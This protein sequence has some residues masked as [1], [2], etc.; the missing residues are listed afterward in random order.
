MSPAPIASRIFQASSSPLSSTVLSTSCL[1]MAPSGIIVA[2]FRYSAAKR[3][4]ESAS[5]ASAPA[6]LA[7]LRMIV[8]RD[9]SWR[10]SAAMSTPVS[11]RS[12]PASNSSP[13]QPPPFAASTRPTSMKARCA[14]RVSTKGC[15]FA[16]ALSARTSAWPSGSPFSAASASSPTSVS[17]QP[18][19]PLAKAA[20]KSSISCRLEVLDLSWTPGSIA[21][22]LPVA[23]ASFEGPWR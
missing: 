11:R 4:V 7:V 16:T 14:S 2:N 19:N 6:P 23:D 22:S 1:S 21:V 9:N 20:F 13:V 18:R 10:A 5:T 3:E 8:R 17:A 15:C 12:S